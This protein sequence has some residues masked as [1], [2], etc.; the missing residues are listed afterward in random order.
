MHTKLLRH[1]SRLSCHESISEESIDLFVLSSSHA[2]G[3][4]LHFQNYAMVSQKYH[5]PFCAKNCKI[6]HHDLVTV[7]CLDSSQKSDELPD[8]LRECIESYSNWDHN[9]E[10]P[11]P[12]EELQCPLMYLA[13]AFGK[14]GLVRALIQDNFDAHAVTSN[15]ETAL[16]G[17]VQ[18]IYRT[19]S[20]KAQ[21]LKVAATLGPIKNRRRAFE[22][23][24]VTLTDVDPKIMFVQDND[25]DT[26]FHVAAEKIWNDRQNDRLGKSATFF[27]SCMSSMLNRMLELEETGEVTRVEILE[28]LNMENNDGDTIFHILARDYAFG[29]KT[30]KEILKKFFPGQVP[31]KVNKE[32]E[33]VSSIALERNRKKA[34]QV[35]PEFLEQSK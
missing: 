5:T 8:L 23:I 22:R 21:G 34:V 14:A 3:V 15:G 35:F 6:E 7:L 10:V 33:T 9:S 28:A 32:N 18:Y 4:L 1:K 30:M 16:H 24:L 25:G 20:L 13:S 27:Q 29:F 19:G 11:D 12:L 26:A 2:H 17:A 31:S